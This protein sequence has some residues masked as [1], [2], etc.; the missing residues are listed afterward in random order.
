MVLVD[1]FPRTSWN[2][3]RLMHNAN[4]RPLLVRLTPKIPAEFVR[5]ALGE[6]MEVLDR[7]PVGQGDESVAATGS[8]HCHG[9]RFPKDWRSHVRLVSYDAGR[10]E[11]VLQPHLSRSDEAS[12]H[13]PP[14]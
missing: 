1:V 9:L 8:G 3:I 11:I 12:F 6:C 14:K 2:S 13:M 10:L 7:F 5:W 4:M